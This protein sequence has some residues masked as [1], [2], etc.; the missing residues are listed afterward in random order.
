LPTGDIQPCNRALSVTV[1]KGE[2]PRSPPLSEAPAMWKKPALVL[3]CAGLCVALL[4]SGLHATDGPAGSIPVAA[5]L[6]QA[7]APTPPAPPTRRAVGV[8]RGEY[9]LI[10][11]GEGDQRA[12]VQLEMFQL[13]CSNQRLVE[14]DMDPLA[15][16][17]PGGLA[18]ALAE[19]GDV[20]L[21][22]RLD[23]QLDL[24]GK[25]SLKLGSRVPTVTQTVVSAKG[26]VTPSVSYD[27]VGTVLE[28]RGAWLEEDGDRADL[29]LSIEASLI[30]RG[31]AMP[32]MS[33]GV[34]LPTFNQFRLQKMLS[35]RSGRPVLMLASQQA[36]AGDG[37]RTSVL[38]VRLT[39][40]RLDG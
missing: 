34:S 23:D 5:Q 21:V 38:F 4:V 3:A 33:E 37:D 11:P 22:T 14:I 17:A 35:V 32:G 29:D 25:L 39:A 18:K 30:G 1:Q 28:I 10:E 16:M 40:T 31:P 7:P 13:T 9:S 2:L 26:T 24:R 20:Q 36:L 8:A 12:R 27:D 15:E 19:H 6:A